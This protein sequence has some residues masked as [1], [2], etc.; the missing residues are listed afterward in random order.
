MDCTRLICLTV[1]ATAGKGHVRIRMDRSC[2]DDTQLVTLLS[3]FV[4]MAGK[5]ALD[6]SAAGL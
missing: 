2:A 3:V 5:Q 4:D 6:L 1:S